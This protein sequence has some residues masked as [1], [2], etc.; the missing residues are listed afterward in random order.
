MLLQLTRFSFVMVIVGESGHVS[1]NIEKEE[2][3]WF[4][5]QF[6]SLSDIRVLLLLTPEPLYHSNKWKYRALRFFLHLTDIIVLLICNW[7]K[8]LD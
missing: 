5:L 1:L 6:R 4:L 2:P 3:E 8:T 7:H